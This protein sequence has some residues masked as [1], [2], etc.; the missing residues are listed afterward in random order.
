MNIFISWSGEIAKEIAEALKEE[1]SSI[2]SGKKDFEVFVS[3]EDI[4]AG[5]EWFNEICSAIDKS[6]CGILC[7]TKENTTS[8]GISDW[9]EFEAGAL[10]FHLNKNNKSVIPLLF[11]VSIPEKAPLKLFEFIKFTSSQYTKLIWD[12]N[13]R[14]FDQTFNKKQVSDLAKASFERLNPKAKEAMKRLVDCERIEIFPKGDLQIA[15]GSIYIA[16]PMAS[17]REPDYQK[18]RS[19]VSNIEET[20]KD[21]CNITDIYAPI[22]KLAEQAEFDGPEKAASENF[23]MLKKAEVLLCLYP[24]PVATSALAEIGYSIA[25]SKKIIIFTS[26]R[27]KSKLPYFLQDGEKS[28]PNLKIYEYESD[29]D[30]IKKIRKN[31]KT[32]L[33]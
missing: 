29:E 13:D 32:F 4:A 3:S 6:V 12:L 22:S 9:I 16:C 28:F 7:L 14:Y 19:I 8:E 30:I 18:Y 20:L 5:M 24:K 25:L 11:D 27:N 31:G 1:L 33:R 15:S 10:A 2:F 17:V 21:Y 26:K 23:E